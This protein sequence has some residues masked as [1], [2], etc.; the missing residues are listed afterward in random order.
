MR[1]KKDEQ[2]QQKTFQQKPFYLKKLGMSIGGE[3]IDVAYREWGESNNGKKL[4]CLHGVT[5]NSHDFDYLAASMCDQY[6][7][8]CSDIPG[9]GESGYFAELDN[10]NYQSYVAANKQVISAVTS[11]EIDFLG[12]S[13]GGLLGMLIASKEDSPIRKLVLNDV[14]PYVPKILF[15]A[16]NAH[17]KIKPK[18]YS[19]IDEAVEFHKQHCSSFGPM[20]DEQWKMFTINGLRQDDGGFIYNYDKKLEA[21]IIQNADADFDIWH[22]WDQIKCPVLVI[23]GETSMALQKEVAEEMTQRGPKADLIEIPVTGHAPTFLSDEQV[24]VVRE[25]LNS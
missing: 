5:R 18:R 14:G 10:Y 19:S 22:V 1:D 2:F 7:V 8:I 9:R 23:R 12:T 4:F 13:M 16:I 11:G 20:S 3:Y 17:E 15:A 6:N 24:S 21:K 25:W